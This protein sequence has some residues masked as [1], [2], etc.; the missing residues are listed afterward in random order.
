MARTTAQL[1]YDPARKKIA[2]ALVSG[3]PLKIEGGDFKLCDCKEVYCGCVGCRRHRRNQITMQ[4][5]KEC[6][7]VGRDYE[8]RKKK[9][10]N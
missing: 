9:N 10:N 1:I 4:H 5:K 8:N 3:L 2:E 6:V 7:Y